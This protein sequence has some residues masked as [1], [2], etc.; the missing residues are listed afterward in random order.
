MISVVTLSYL[1]VGALFGYVL[2]KIENY[3]R[4]MRDSQRRLEAELLNYCK[5]CPLFT[6]SSELTEEKK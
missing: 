4:D 3:I 6:P 1:M 5:G 2:G